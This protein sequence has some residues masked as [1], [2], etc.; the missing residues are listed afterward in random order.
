MA[1]FNLESIADLPGK[2]DLLAAGLLDA[3]LPNDFIVPDPQLSLEAA[4]DD[5]P[6]DAGAQTDF[7]VDFLGA[8]YLDKE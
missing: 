7:V 2:E 1:H 3:H 6:E 8:P 4:D 5:M